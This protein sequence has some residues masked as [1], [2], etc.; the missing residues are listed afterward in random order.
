MTLIVLL[1]RTLSIWLFFLFCFVF[2]L[3]FF[4][5]MCIRV[6]NGEVFSIFYMGVIFMFV[7]SNNGCGFFTFQLVVCSLNLSLTSVLVPLELLLCGVSNSPMCYWVLAL[8]WFEMSI[9]C[10]G[11]IKKSL[12][13]TR[14][15]YTEIYTCYRVSSIHLSLWTSSDVNNESILVEN[16]WDL[17]LIFGVFVYY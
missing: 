9:N 6:N 8:N 7:I 12:T 1:I 4:L 13:C 17:F 5:V 11:F 3:F 10:H 2:V 16:T 15:R 14:C